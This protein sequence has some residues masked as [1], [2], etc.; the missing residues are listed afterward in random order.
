ME[1]LDSQIST[2]RKMLF[3]LFYRFSHLIVV[4]EIL[5]RDFPGLPATIKHYH[6]S[7]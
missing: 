2:A 4:T 3:W 6:S 7:K 5:K 1:A